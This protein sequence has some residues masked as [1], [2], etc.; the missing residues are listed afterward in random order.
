MNFE[1]KRFPEDNSN[2]QA[3]NAA[4]EYLLKQSENLITQNSLLILN[5]TNGFLGVNLNQFNP[6]VYSDSYININSIEKNCIANGCKKNVKTFFSFSKLAELDFKFEIVL[7]KIPKSV[8]FFE[9]LI[10]SIKPLLK[11]NS[12]LICAGMTKHLSDNTRKILEN[13]FGK[14]DISKVYKKSIS[15]ISKYEIHNYDNMN[16]LFSNIKDDEF[17]LN[18]FSLPNVFSANKLDIGTK[19]LLKNLDDVNGKVVDLGCGAGP[20]GLVCKKNDPS[21]ELFM[22]DESYQAV[23]SAQ[24][25]FNEAQLDAEFIWND[26]LTFLKENSIDFVLSN[27]P[28][29]NETSV[30]MLTG[31]RLFKEASR[32]LKKKG[33]FKLVFNKTLS[34]EP[35]LKKLFSQVQ[36]ID[37]NNRFVVYDCTK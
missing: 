37:K 32:V 29:H 8:R 13:R 26:G 23:Q 11:E 14:T 35:H 31:L 27:P 3:W 10:E 7:I 2:L 18:F 17:N 28:F 12:M 24:K 19:L 9:Y 36:K 21:I 33:V 22:M 6:V 5:D 1:I 25:T 30:N 20:I 16:L 4:D 15:F 34:Y